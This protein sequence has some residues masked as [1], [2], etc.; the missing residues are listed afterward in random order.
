MTPLALPALYAIVDPLDTGRSPID[1]AAALLQGGARLLQLRLKAAPARKVLEI[2]RVVRP[3]AQQAGALLIV[4][5]RPDVARA[6]GADG[7]HLGQDDLPVAAARTVLGAGGIVGVSTH[8]VGQARAAVAAGADY[9][10]VGPVFETT[11]KVGALAA[12]G[13]DLVRAVRHEVT[14]PLVAIGG[15]TP[16][17]APEVRAAG[18]DAVA[19][20]AALVRAPDVAAAV[21]DTLARLAPRADR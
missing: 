8:S 19:M 3:L 4:N 20:I 10:G 16:T 11:S 5:D 12:R 18:A 1:L 9:L 2:A 7:V 15:I 17:T 14:L 6:A 13:L 21:R